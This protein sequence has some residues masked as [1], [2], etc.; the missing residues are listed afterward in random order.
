[1]E[2]SLPAFYWNA[3]DC[4]QAVE[5]G[6][7]SMPM[8]FNFNKF[9]QQ[10]IQGEKSWKLKMERECKK[11]S[12]LMCLSLTEIPLSGSIASLFLLS[13]FQASKTFSEG[14]F[15]VVLEEFPLK[16]STWNLS[17]HLNVASISG[18]CWRY[19]TIKIRKQ[20]SRMQDGKTRGNVAE[21]LQITFSRIEFY[22]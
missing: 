21:N 10:N 11:G 2:T 16:F 14:I 8:S 6:L 9:S 20:F 17:Q 18:F 1:M 22:N 15:L 4:P 19:K 5:N 3:F 13:C 12:W 7:N